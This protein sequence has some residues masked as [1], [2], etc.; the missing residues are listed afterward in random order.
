M[1]D[2]N[3]PINSE[4]TPEVDDTL[5]PKEGEEYLDEGPGRVL[6]DL[7]LLQRGEADVVCLHLQ[8]GQVVVQEELFILAGHAEQILNNNNI[9]GRLLFLCFCKPSSGL[10]IDNVVL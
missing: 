3:V 5:L 9:F 2:L 7:G 10:A 4:L 8:L 1:Y 6:Q